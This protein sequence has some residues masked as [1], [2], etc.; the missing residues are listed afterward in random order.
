MGEELG[1][2]DRGSRKAAGGGKADG[3]GSK[4]DRERDVGGI[5]SPHPKVLGKKPEA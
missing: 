1:T 2:G 4:W 3:R 5:P